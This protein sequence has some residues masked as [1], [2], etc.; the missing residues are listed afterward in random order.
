V[1]PG[2]I[3]AGKYRVDRVLG[4]GGMGVVVAATHVDLLEPRAIKFMLADHLGDT[5]AVA[6]F[7]REAR[8]CAHLKGQHIAKVHDVGRLENGAPY[9]I[10][11]Y[12]TGYDLGAL[13]DRRGA[14]PA[15]EAALHV[16]QVC[17]ALAEAHAAGIVHRDL[18][19]E[20]VF[21][22]QGP[23][24]VMSVKV[25]DFGISMV[26]HTEHELRMTQA[27][28]IMGSPFYMSPEQ[29]RSSRDVD[30]RTD[31]WS[32]GILLYQLVTGRLPFQGENLTEIISA[33]LFGQCPP[34]SSLVRGLPD[35]LED[36]IL[37]CLERDLDR[38]YPSVT[39]LAEDL[40]PYAPA[41]GRQSVEQILRLLPRGSILAQDS[42]S[43]GTVAGEPS[44]ATSGAWRAARP[45]AERSR[46]PRVPV[47]MF[48]AGAALSLL[49]AGGVFFLR[50][51]GVTIGDPTLKSPAVHEGAAT[52]AAPASRGEATVAPLPATAKPMV[53]PAVT[54]IEVAP[55]PST[56]TP[57]PPVA[58]ATSSAAALPS[59]KRQAT[60]S[61][62]KPVATESTPVTTPPPP[63]G[64]PFGS[65]RQ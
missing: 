23:G 56:D 46:R 53:S 61:P 37:R 52:E 45:G 10:M 54:A 15:H 20:N 39:E 36:V 21:L 1:S 25:L 63:A 60:K 59:G 8:A 48:A 17:E 57:S 29:T 4:V 42:V 31:I 40:A 62:P 2:D 33:V 44:A 41:G 30:T 58:S 14:I 49:I 50:G 47:L 7:L 11:E 24:G 32:L 35:G 28:T 19:P 6:R 9:L 55:S 64:D 12:L 51:R 27:T 65:G 13:I 3:L 38:R 26:L 43:A 22:A 16:L 18:K 34:P 5:E